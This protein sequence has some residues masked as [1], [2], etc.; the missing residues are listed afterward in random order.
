MNEKTFSNKNISNNIRNQIIMVNGNHETIKY[1]STG[2]KVSFFF[3][4]N[5]LK[6]CFNSVFLLSPIVILLW[7]KLFCLDSKSFLSWL[8]VTRDYLLRH[9]SL[10]PQYPSLKPASRTSSDT[11][12]LDC[13]ANSSFTLASFICFSTFLCCS[14]NVPYLSLALSHD[15]SSSWVT[16]TFSMP[17][18]SMIK[19][20]TSRSATMVPSVVEYL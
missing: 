3:P 18:L 2:Y 11:A 1:K 15:L 7:H 8:L 9:S 6:T 14:R 20:L 17:P 19:S 5:F 4:S 13:L 16:L 10:Q 12:S